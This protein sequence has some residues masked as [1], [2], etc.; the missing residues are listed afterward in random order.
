MLVAVPLEATEE[1]AERSVELVRVDLLVCL[2]DVLEDLANV[3]GNLG[4]LA[5]IDIGS[6]KLG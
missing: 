6:L 5:H 1:A 3:L 4:R 2:G